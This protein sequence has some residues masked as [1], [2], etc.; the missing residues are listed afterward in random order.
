MDDASK[1]IENL[2][3]K[4][5]AGYK[6]L[7]AIRDY[8][9]KTRDMFREIQKENKIYKDQVL[10]QGKVLELLKKQIQHLQ[11]KTQGNKATG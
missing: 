3:I 2:A 11:I 7:I 10:E 8:S 5:T 6:N 1:E 4:E 9:V